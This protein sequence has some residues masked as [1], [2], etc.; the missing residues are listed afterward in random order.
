M[1]EN[2]INT[3][4]IANKNTKIQKY[5]NNTTRIQETQ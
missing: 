5:H 3:K 4:K 1:P 2:I